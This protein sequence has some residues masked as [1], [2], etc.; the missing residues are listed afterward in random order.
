LLADV[1]AGGGTWMN[2]TIRSSLFTDGAMTVC[3]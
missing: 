3:G 1:S 2:G